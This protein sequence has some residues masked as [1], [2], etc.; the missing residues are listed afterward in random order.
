LDRIELEGLLDKTSVTSIVDAVYRK[1]KHKAHILD[2]VAPASGR[3]LFGPTETISFM[4][5]RE[6]LYEEQP[7]NFAR[8]FYLAIG[9]DPTGKALVIASNGLSEVS[10]G[11]GTR[12][13]RLR[14]HG[15]SGSLIDGRVRDFNELTNY[16]CAIFCRGQTMKWG[17]DR[18]MPFAPKVPVAIAGVFIKPGDYVVADNS[19][20]VVVPAPDI[21]SVLTE[22]VE[23]E[24]ADV[25]F[26][27][28]IKTKRA[29]DVMRQGS[30]E[31]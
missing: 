3:R 16:N 18:L 9:D 4:P 1:Y 10:L 8:L 22:T 19:G 13:S 27:R 21:H 31:V 20:A 14:N 15:L 7:H 12:L 26:V 6:D 23:I 28:T 17:G 11:G 30:D 5:F 24:K 2:L 29:E 25:A